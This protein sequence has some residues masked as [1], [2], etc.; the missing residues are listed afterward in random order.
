MG[1]WVDPRCDLD[2]L[3]ETVSF[4]TLPGIERRFFGITPG[5][6]T[7]RTE[8]FRLVP[9]TGTCHMFIHSSI[10]SVMLEYLKMRECS[11]NMLFLEMKDYF[12]CF[13]G[14]LEASYRTAV[15]KFLSYRH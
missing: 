6:V 2:I 5:D 4:C 15:M 10:Q 8:V 9:S 1:R 3:E 13:A 12:R 7:L 11:W 14:N